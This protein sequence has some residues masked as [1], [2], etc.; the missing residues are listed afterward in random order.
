MSEE[1]PTKRR[2]KPRAVS[3]DEALTPSETGDLSTPNAAADAQASPRS[4][5]PRKSRA[6]APKAPGAALP[7]TNSQID[8]FEAALAKAALIEQAL[9][10]EDAANIEV[11]ADYSAL[12]A[13]QGQAQLTPAASDPRWVAAWLGVPAPSATTETSAHED[14]WTTETPAT[15]IDLSSSCEDPPFDAPSF[16]ELSGAGDTR[17]YQEL[18][19]D[20]PAPREAPRDLARPVASY[21]LNSVVHDP[22]KLDYLVRAR[23]AAQAQAQL[24]QPRVAV[25]HLSPW[26]I[27]A[28]VAAPLLALSAWGMLNAVR[29]HA[30]A[31]LVGAS[32]AAQPATATGRDPAMDYQR[33]L[34]LLDSGRARDGLALLQSA[35]DAGL[36]PAQYRLAKIY[37]HGDG[38]PRDLN[39]AREWTERAARGGNCRAMHDLGVYYAQGESVQRNETL[40]FSWFQQ[41]ASLGV[42]DSQYNLGLLYQH[43]RGVE[44]NV[45]NALFWFLVAARQHD[46]NAIDRA[47]TLAAQMAPD[48]VERAQAR[49]RRFEARQSDPLANGGGA[50]CAAP[51]ERPENS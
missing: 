12:A 14:S 36:A 8:P 4:A 50:S 15:L 32:A 34:Q 26:T 5:K 22:G 24:V 25:P 29:G 3:L 46:L 43:G 45:D 48:Q 49:A 44:A 28:G 39:A 18:H 11:V 47:V 7:P 21:Q 10:S 51:L 23:Q 6:K 9:A 33:G 17:V 35:A 1:Q 2:R 27:A 42:V 16:D 37:E 38:A 20:E 31:T 13:L 40:A 41:A 19:E 30:D